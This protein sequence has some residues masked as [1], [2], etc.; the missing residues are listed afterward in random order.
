MNFL[1]DEFKEYEEYRA[2]KDKII[3]DLKSDVDS[4]STEIEKLEKLKDQQQQYSRRNYP[5]V[6]RIVEEKEEITDE[7]II[8][9]LN[10]TLYLDI[11]LWDLEKPIE[12]ENV[13]KTRRKTCPIIVKFVRCN[14]RNRVFRNKKKLKGLKISI[15]ESLTKIRMDKLRQ[16]KE[17]Y[18]FTNVWTNDGKIF[19]KLDSN[20]K[21]QAYYS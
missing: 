2:K 13:K 6:N 7:V 20:A 15:T 21:P 8:N 4:L 17:T 18:G 9:T 16:A 19:F 10:E 5:L 12:L 3:E 11:S 14:D 1:P